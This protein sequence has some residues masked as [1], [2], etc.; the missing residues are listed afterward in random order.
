VHGFTFS[1]HFYSPFDVEAVGLCGQTFERLLHGFAAE[2]EGAVV[3]GN[4]L[5]GAEIGESADG[6]LGAGV[7]GA[8]A[9]GEVGADGQQGNL[10][11]QFFADGLEAVEVS[12]VA[13]VIYGLAT[14]FDD[15]SAVAAMGVAKDTRAPVFA[16]GHSYLEVQDV[17][18]LPPRE[19]VDVG[20]AEALDQVFDAAGD[21]DFRGVAGLP[22][23]GTN[24][25]AE[26]CHVEVIHVR[27]RE[28]D[29]ID[30]RELCDQD[31]GAALATKQNQAFGKDG[32][33]EDSAA[34]DLEEEGGVP[35]ECDSQVFGS[36][37]FH[38]TGSAGHGIFVA[39]A[40]ESPELL[41]LSHREGPALPCSAHSSHQ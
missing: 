15:V 23:R 12:S 6:F 13:R 37:E 5:R 2:T 32:V 27:V 21:D 28:E 36:G 22:T 8:V 9:V 35:D 3:H 30:G 19:A 31:A 24:D 11:F 18:L 25:L 16:G 17:E 7:D 33:H 1:K 20:E 29:E 41:H 40:D 10:G 34:V 14:A 38:R 4:H 26:G 39:F